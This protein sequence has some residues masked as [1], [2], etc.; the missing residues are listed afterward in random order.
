MSNLKE[1]SCKS[2]GA[3]LIFDP[4]TQMSSCNFCGTK[5]EIDL[6]EKSN[7][8]ITPDKLFPFSITKDQFKNILLIWL[9]KGDYTPDDILTS[10]IFDEINGLYLPQYLYEGSYSG[11]WS[12]SSGYKKTESYVVVVDSKVKTKKRKFTDW[13]PS[14]GQVANKYSILAFAGNLDVLPS[15]IASFM[16]QDTFDKEDLKPFKSEYTSGFNIVPFD[17]DFENVWQSVGYKKAKELCL[18]DIKQ[19]IPGDKYKDLV[20]DMNCEHIRITNILSPAYIVNY[21]FG[22]KKFNVYMDG[23][24]SKRIEGERPIDKARQEKVQL[25]KKP[26][27]RFWW[28]SGITTFAIVLIY[29]NLSNDYRNGFETVIFPIFFLLMLIHGTVVHIKSKKS[30]KNLLSNSKARRQTILKSMQDGTSIPEELK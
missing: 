29:S 6:A 17:L 1:I 18:S 12:A 28:L 16:N 2:C 27:R 15:T 9:S 7:L 19:R 24:K 8:V 22:G 11:N 30:I 25:L 5:F 14:N 20:Y 26:I 23:D 3:S 13:R 21:E 10:S 4:A